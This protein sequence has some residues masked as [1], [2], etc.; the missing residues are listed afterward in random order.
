L[1]TPRSEPYLFGSRTRQATQ[2]CGHLRLP[3]RPTAPSTSLDPPL[4]AAIN[5]AVA[6]RRVCGAS[7]HVAPSNAPALALY[8]SWGFHVDAAVPDYYGPG[9]DAL[10][11]ARDLEGP[12]EGPLPRPSHPQ[13]RS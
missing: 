10:R 1:W 6:R 9:L 2:S 4:Q 7:L 3:K 8:R 12:L 13:L 11:M 5:A